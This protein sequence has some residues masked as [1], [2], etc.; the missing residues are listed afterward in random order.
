MVVI[1]TN[2][3]IERIRSNKEINENITELTLLEHPPILK[4]KRFYGGIYYLKRVDL[5]LALKIQIKLRKIGR[6]KPIADILIAAIC[7]NRGE[8]LVT[9][10]RDF[11][12]IARVSNL[13]VK[14]VNNKKH[15]SD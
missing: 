8:T 11:L 14:L 6:P 2:I 5:N 10:D 3:A 15:S 9:R 13:K 1:D 7:I 4:Y 12:D